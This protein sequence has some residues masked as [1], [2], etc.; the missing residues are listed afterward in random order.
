MRSLKFKMASSKFFLAL[1]AIVMGNLLMWIPMI[2]NVI[3]G[4]SLILLTGSE[5][6]SLILGVLG[7]YMGTN[8]WQKKVAKP[9]KN[10]T[11]EG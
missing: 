7:V 9:P 3:F 8:V 5:Y 10:E 1:L 2:I 11:E 6:V 4:M